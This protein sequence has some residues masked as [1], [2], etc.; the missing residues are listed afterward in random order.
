M[1]TEHNALV[2]APLVAGAAEHGRIIGRVAGLQ[3]LT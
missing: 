3:A 2:D 1:N